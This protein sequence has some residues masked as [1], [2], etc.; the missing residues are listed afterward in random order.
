MVFD[1]SSLCTSSHLSLRE[2]D[3][4]KVLLILGRNIIDFC[5]VFVQVGDISKLASS[6]AFICCDICP[7]LT[8]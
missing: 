7:F 5:C 8:A 2:Y 3:Y 6:I 4:K 1:A